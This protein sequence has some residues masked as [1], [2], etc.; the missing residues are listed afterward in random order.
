MLK[1]L[2]F[3]LSRELAKVTALALVVITLVMTVFAMIEPL[4]KRGLATDQVV[5]LFGYTLPV[6]VSLTLPVA[7]LF[8]ATVVYGRFSQD[9]E[10]MACRASGI[11]T[12]S[13]LKPALGLGA[14]VTVLALV[15]SS[16]VAPRLL[17]I[18]EKAVKA[19]IRGILYHQLGSQGYVKFGNIIMHADMV[20]AK[21][22]T[23][24][25]VAVAEKRPEKDVQLF[26]S[27]SA[28]VDFV[29]Q[30]DGMAVFIYPADVLGPISTSPG[31]TVPVLEEGYFGPLIPPSLTKEKPSWYTWNRLIQ[32]L[33][34]PSDHPDIRKNVENIRRLLM[35]EML[36]RELTEA[37]EAGREY[38]LE[39]YD[40]KVHYISAARAEL[41]KGQHVRLMCSRPDEP[42]RRRVK[43]RTPQDQETWTSDFAD[44]VVSRAIPGLER[45]PKVTITMGGN[46]EG[47]STLGELLGGEVTRKNV[48]VMPNIRIPDNIR[49]KVAGITLADLY[50]RPND[51]TSNER[52]LTIIAWLKTK[53]IDKI[54][55]EI[56]AEIHGRFAYG[57]SCFLLVGLGAALGLAFRGGQVVSAFAISMAP[58]TLVIVMVLMGKE[59]VTNPGVIHG[60]AWG[61]SAIW[62]GDLAL[63]VACA[64]M[65]FRLARK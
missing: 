64:W 2:H 33:R 13:L 37:I 59:I 51:Y 56:F 53:K 48:H 19:N 41:Y 20:N 40:S 9:N 12:L 1:T 8:A 21:E 5:M 18:G 42:D 31:G 65:Y 35:H 23:L 28:R 57:V 11:P 14:I 34:D 27:V 36:A 43:I 10:L 52:I 39:S 61:L 26:T 45:E 62:G 6:M 22:N 63:L 32:M 49:K 38:R 54:R 4:R 16:F 25:G 3:H 55:S 60:W 58:A 15:L 47:R 17:A 29:P 46:V 7:A 50:H 24:W 44:V 30:K